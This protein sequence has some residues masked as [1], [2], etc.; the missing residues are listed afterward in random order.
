MRWM[1]KPRY[2][3]QLLLLSLVTSQ[4]IWTGW[5]TLQIHCPGEQAQ[6]VLHLLRHPICLH[7]YCWYLDFAVQFHFLPSK[8]LP[9]GGALSK[10]CIT[11]IFFLLFDGILVVPVPS[12][13]IIYSLCINARARRLLNWCKVM[14]SLPFHRKYL[15]ARYVLTSETARRKASTQRGHQWVNQVPSILGT[16]CF[17]LLWLSTSCLYL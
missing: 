17:K 10:T 2:W 14:I 5:H 7:V 3:I 1:K 6:K 9:C 12:V 16:L 11:L 15:R 8:N 4:V 13:V